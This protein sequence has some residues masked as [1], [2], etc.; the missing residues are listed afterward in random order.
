ML[1]TIFGLVGVVIGGVITFASSY[2]LESQKAARER[3]REER[4]RAASL[5]LAARIV[6]AEIADALSSAQ[7]TLENK[8]WGPEPLRPELTDW[9]AHRIT[10]A[11]ELSGAEWVAVLRAA[12]TIET[13]TDLVTHPTN[14]GGMLFPSTLSVLQNLIPAFQQGREALGPYCRAD[15]I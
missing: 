12:I 1:A 15:S 2:F 6:D 9:L 14:D 3:E 10:L 8:R 11:A 5:R 13:L 4:T 7:F